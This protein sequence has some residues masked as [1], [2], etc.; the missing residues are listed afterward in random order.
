MGTANATGTTSTSNYWQDLIRS[1]K[2][3]STD[4]NGNPVQGNVLSSLTPQQ[5]SAYNNSLTGMLTGSSYA[6]QEGAAQEAFARAAQNMKA[7]TAQ[8]SFGAVGQGAAANAQNQTQQ[9][10]FSG[11][12]TNEL[13]VAKGRVDLQQQ[14]IS[15]ANALAGM[16]EGQRQFNV[17]T[18]LNYTQLGSSND[19]GQ[20]AQDLNNSQ[21]DLQQQQFDFTKQQT[22]QTQQDNSRSALAAYFSA[23]APNSTDASGAPVYDW[24]KDPE[25]QRRVQEAGYDP[26][27]DSGAISSLEKSATMSA[28]DRALVDMQQSSWYQNLSADEKTQMDQTVIPQLSQLKAL[29]GSITKD[30]DGNIQ[31][32]DSAGNIIAGKNAGGKNYTDPLGAALQKQGLDSST[33]ATLQEPGWQD[34]ADKISSNPTIL[35]NPSF[36]G[37]DAFKSN[38][39]ALHTYDNAT[40]DADK[41]A[42]LKNMTSDSRKYLLQTGLVSLG[43]LTNDNGTVIY[44]KDTIAAA[45]QNPN[46]S[47]LIATSSV[48][49]GSSWNDVRGKRA[50][51][52]IS[53]NAKQWVSDNTGKV[54]VVNIPRTFDSQGRTANIVITG[55]SP[56]SKGRDGYGR[57]TG[58]DVSTGKVVTTDSDGNWSI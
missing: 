40:T 9:N 48:S 19:L 53:D 36:G 11:L 27:K 49:L 33:I 5:Q 18:D 38:M 30:A 31:I 4:P 57:V 15:D 28:E 46:N 2:S 43:K 8:N 23:A 7:Q 20:Q 37:V 17:G 29:G 13:N 42:A 51:W 1:R 24:T 41:A 47:D 52:D 12:A 32:V 55:Y 58:Y 6:P 56:A 21:L 16:N 26:T 50:R 10:I 39:T 44:D 45:L 3:L 25:A 22:L 34:V 35:S 54:I 14:G